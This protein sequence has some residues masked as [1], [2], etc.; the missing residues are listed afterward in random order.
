MTWVLL[1][2]TVDQVSRV[3]HQNSFYITSEAVN[4]ANTFWKHRKWVTVLIYPNGRNTWVN[5]MGMENLPFIS[6]M[7]I[8]LRAFPACRRF[9]NWTKAKPRIFPSVCKCTKMLEGA[10]GEP[11]DRRRKLRQPRVAMAQILPTGQP[12]RQSVCAPA[13]CTLP[14]AQREQCTFSKCNFS[15]KTSSDLTKN[16]IRDTWL[17]IPN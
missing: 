6:F 1:S 14:W 12:L 2:L 8:L 15:S 9:L 13:E 17:K 4:N 3:F 11:T 16:T 10:G 5:G 7:F